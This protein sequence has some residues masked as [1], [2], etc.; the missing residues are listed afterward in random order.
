MRIYPL[1][2]VVASIFS[3]CVSDGDQLIESDMT[4]IL[5]RL[6]REY[7]QLPEKA[8]SISDDNQVFAM[9]ASPTSVYGHGILG[10]KIEAKQLVVV[11]RGVFH[12]LSLG[13][14]VVFEDI[15][16]RLYDADGDGELEIITIRTEFSDG[17]GIGIYKLENNQ[18]VE[19]AAVPV[20][21]KAYRWLNIVAINDLDDDG[22][23]ELAWIE[24][25]HIGGILKVAKIN[26]GTLEV[27]DS[28]REYSNHSIGETNLCLSALA[29]MNS[30]KVI[31]IPSQEGDSIVG[32]VFKDG[33]LEKIEEISI[34]VD[35]TQSLRSQYNFDNII[36]QEVNCI[37]A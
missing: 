19:Y 11:R 13:D 30:L 36:D 27:L 1:L 22:V 9:Y 16:P 2:L 25:P 6:S 24:T 23:V 5:D 12:E 37:T 10:D 26:Q 18:L 20:I 34:P 31:Y 17:A 7:E 14:R 35:F 8:I 32:Y 33:L 15:R 4:Y 29:I 28:K 21:G 3:S